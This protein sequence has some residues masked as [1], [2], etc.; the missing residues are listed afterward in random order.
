MATTRWSA[1]LM[2]AIGI[3]VLGASLEARAAPAPARP[4]KSVHV[5]VPQNSV[6][7]LVYLG[8]RDAGIYRKH[9]INVTVDARPFA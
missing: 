5:V 3:M 9:G 2:G 1:A 6:D 7:A 4:L 8:G